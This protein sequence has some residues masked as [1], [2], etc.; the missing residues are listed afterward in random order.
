MIEFLKPQI[1]FIQDENGV[2]TTSPKVRLGNNFDGGYIIPEIAINKSVALFTYGVADDFSYETDYNNKY[3]KPVYMFD[4]TIKQ[5]SWI[6]GDIHFF[7]EGLGFSSN[8]NDFIEHYKQFDI[9]G[10]VLLKIDV[11][12]AEFP[13]FDKVDIDKLSSLVTGLIMEIHFIHEPYRIRYAQTIL[14][15]INKHFILTHIHGNNY[16]DC[17]I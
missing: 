2:K 8:C 14:E 17:L 4:H 11:E 16:N 1:I 10:E 13:Y 6:K 3:K 9:K 7:N 5:D 12:A 15:K